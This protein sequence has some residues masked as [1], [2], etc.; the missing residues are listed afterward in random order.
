MSSNSEYLYGTYGHIENSVVDDAVETELAAVYVGT[1]PVHLVRG[2]KNLN[3]V[4]EPVKLKNITAKNIIGYSSDKEKYTLS[5]VIDAHFDNVK[6]NVG[7]IYVINILD[8]STHCTEA[9]EHTLTFVNG[10]A[11]I[12]SDTI[13]LDTF[14]IEGKVENTDYTLAYNYDAGKLTITSIGKTKDTKLDGQVQCTYAEVDMSMITDTVFRGKKENGVYTGVHVLEK[15]YP[16][17]GVVPMY[18]AAPG[19]TDNPDNYAYL[20]DT[21][22]QI[23]GH[24]FGFVYADLPIQDKTDPIDTFDKAKKWRAD[25][26]YFKSNSKIYWPMAYIIGKGAFHLSTLAVVEK[27]RVDNEKGRPCG[28]DGNKVI[29]IDYHYF[30]EESNNEGYDQEDANELV[31]DGI[32]TIAAWG[33]QFKLWGDHTAAYQFSKKDAIDKRLYFDANVIMLNYTLNMFQEMYGGKID[34]T[35]TKADKD[36]IT[37]DFEEWLGALVADG[38]LVGTP[39]VMFLETNNST[40][41]IMEGRFVWNVLQT[42]APLFK[43]AEC[44]AAYTSAGISEFL[45]EE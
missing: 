1:A 20:C 33:G 9:N 6:G 27:M 38:A 2:Y 12:V 3:L 21:C 43:V 23:N 13:I 37:H 32:S 24:W 10:E 26:D 11:V 14:G 41:G 35:I 7:P 15:M 36:T 17:Y 45:E 29:P 5:E 28:T 39:K 42:N 16:F 44:Y 22:Y 34:D 4:N 25:N 31:Q 8:P 40:E 18:V 19:F 30:G